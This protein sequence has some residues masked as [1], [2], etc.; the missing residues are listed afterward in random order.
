M[1]ILLF[2]IIAL[3][4][5]SSTVSAQPCE[6]VIDSYLYEPSYCMDKILRGQARQYVPQ[7]GDVMLATDKN[8]SMQ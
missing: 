2:L 3:F 8:L 6:K 4:A 7:P 5:Y 1:R